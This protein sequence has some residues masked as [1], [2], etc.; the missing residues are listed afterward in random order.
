VPIAEP[1][2]ITQA[3]I[4]AKAI[5][6]CRMHREYE[7]PAWVIEPKKWEDWSSQV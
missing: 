4:S 1:G 3:L 5:L 7:V 2:R 6:D